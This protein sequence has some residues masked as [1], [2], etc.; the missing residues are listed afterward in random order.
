MECLKNALLFNKNNDEYLNLK[1]KDL[2]DF[3]NSFFDRIDEDKDDITK[4]KFN[5]ILETRIKSL[6][7][8]ISI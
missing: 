7:N 1:N 8:K 3:I 5:F 4:D 6:I 2:P